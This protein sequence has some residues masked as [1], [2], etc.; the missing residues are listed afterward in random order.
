IRV[1]PVHDSIT[2]I[3]DGSGMNAIDFDKKFAWISHSTKRRDSEFSPNLNRPLI[4]KIGIGFIAVNEICNELEI[5]SSKQG[6][7]F[8]FIAKIDFKKYFE[9]ATIS[10]DE[11]GGIIKGEYKLINEYEDSD[12]HYTII[13]LVGLKESVRNI[14]DDKQ[15]LAEK[16]KERNK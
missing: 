10:E 8:K 16:L 5:T 2:I 15:Y 4:G 1:K 14:L 7:E 6:E 3:D 13:R 12:E 11:E 9:E